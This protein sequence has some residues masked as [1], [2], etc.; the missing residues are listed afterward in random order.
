M[1]NLTLGDM[2]VVGDWPAKIVKALAVIADGLHPALDARHEEVIPGKSKECCILCAL[3]VRDFLRSIGFEAEA[4]SVSILMEAQRN[5][6]TLHSLGLGCPAEAYGKH[7]TSKDEEGRW[8]GH[9]VTVLPRLK[10]LVDST[11]YQAQRQQWDGALTGMI[12]LPYGNV[13]DR[14]KIYRCK[15]LAGLQMHDAKSGAEFAAAWLDRPDNQ[16]WKRGGDV[17]EWRR[18]LPVLQLRSAFGAWRD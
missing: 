12:A 4:R 16:G 14:R 3:T 1:A 5:G 11:L 13:G 9:L 2:T 17:E 10:L 15:V 18:H 8:D 7:G 6:E